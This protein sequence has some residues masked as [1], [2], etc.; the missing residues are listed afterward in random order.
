MKKSFCSDLSP[1]TTCDT[2]NQLLVTDIRITTDS[3]DDAGDETDLK[4][5]IGERPQN[6]LISNANTS[7][8]YENDRYHFNCDPA[9]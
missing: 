5:T 6:F 3:S 8:Q 7:F 9:M 1:Q 2:D 4:I